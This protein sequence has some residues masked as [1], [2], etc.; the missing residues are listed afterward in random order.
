MDSIDN[1]QRL[2]RF[3]TSE[4]LKQFCKKPK[5][6]ILESSPYTWI[7]EWHLNLTESEKI[8]L[9]CGSWEGNAASSVPSL[10]AER[11][12]SE[13]LN[14]KERALASRERTG[15]NQDLQITKSSQLN[16]R[17]TLKLR[18]KITH[19]KMSN[20]C[21]RRVCRWPKLNLHNK[22]EITGR[23]LWR[24]K[25]TG[26]GCGSLIQEAGI[27]SVCEMISQR[28][29]TSTHCGFQKKKNSE[30]TYIDILSPSKDSLFTAV[31]WIYS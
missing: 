12:D 14:E 26:A 30:G 3:L 31:I 8:K 24:S 16:S 17:K 11:R 27:V 4:K 6:C 2:K 5:R 21:Y 19:L 28:W 23:R 9:K 1:F 18:S 25:A 13:T 20:F 7:V 22:G 29:M 15:V 10:F